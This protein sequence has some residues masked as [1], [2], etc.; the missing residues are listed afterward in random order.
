MRTPSRGRHRRP[1]APAL[2]LLWAGLLAPVLAAAGAIE[3]Y[4]DARFGMSAGQVLETVEASDQLE[5]LSNQVLGQ[6]R[7]IQAKR[8]RNW[9]DSRVLY[10]LPGD[11]DHLALVIETFPDRTD[12]APIIEELKAH[13]GPPMSEK[14]AEQILQR[15]RRGLPQGVQ[16][17]TLWTDRS[18]DSNRMVRLL[19]FE[20][21]LA[22]EHLDPDLMAE[23]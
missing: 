12:A 15:M 19:H 5:L 13:L 18:G 23:R 11:R 8:S 22:I 7:V 6:D 10:V 17:L 20:D 14:M 2:T 1:P 4:L 3:G 9:A 21:H 16:K